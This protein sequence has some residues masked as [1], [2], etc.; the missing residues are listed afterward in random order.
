MQ[1][2]KDII[3]VAAFDVDGTLLPNGINQFSDNTKKIFKE[4]KKNGVITVISTA[5]E[6]ATIGDFLEQLEP[7][8]YFIGANGSFIWDVQKKDFLYKSTLI[9]E[10]VVDLY[11]QFASQVN[12]FS[13]ADF[14]KVYK[15]PKMNLDS[16]FVRPFQENYKNFDEA[17]LSRND[18]Y[19][20]TINCDNTRELSDEISKYI[21]EK[22][23]QMEISAR[24]TRGFFISPKNITKSH[25][26]EI[27]CE[28]L[29]Y[30]INNLIAFGDSSN[31][32][33]MIRDA[34]YGVAMERANDK[35]KRVA[36]D[37]ALDCEYDGV[38]WKLKELKLI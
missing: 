9:K 37:I 17:Y 38:Y 18:L 16:W 21:L 23:Y 14:N 3:K 34:Y 7:V 26:L 29:G 1:N 31:D 4:L 32:F 33:E 2:L 10:E 27:L 12:G 30:S 19:V 24:W 20:I 35:I 28:K 25:T 13:V 5:R 22:G 8:D 36:K 15:S 6:F 11:D